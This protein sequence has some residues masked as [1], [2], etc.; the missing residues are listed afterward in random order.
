VKNH[1][2]P[3]SV[4]KANGLKGGKECYLSYDLLTLCLHISS[5]FLKKPRHLVRSFRMTQK[6]V[7]FFNWVNYVNSLQKGV[8]N[9]IPFKKRWG[10]FAISAKVC[11]SNISLQEGDASITSQCRSDPD[12]GMSTFPGGHF[13]KLEIVQ[14]TCQRQGG[15]A[16]G[17]PA[18]GAGKQSHLWRGK[19][20]QV[21]EFSHFARINLRN[22]FCLKCLENH[23]S[24]KTKQYH[25]SSPRAKRWQ[26]CLDRHIP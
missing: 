1:K 25:I 4:R 16:R 7:K 6:E 14:E 3:V 18:S 20:W 2:P 15:E 13:G 17:H 21:Y 9:Y 19:S 22:W 8:K 11:K 23:G 10:Y 12:T 24:G 5:S 26:T